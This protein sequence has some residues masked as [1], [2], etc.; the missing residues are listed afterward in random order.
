[1]YIC[2]Q[3]YS[4]L[5]QCILYTYAYNNSWYLSQTNT[6]I[7]VHVCAHTHTHTHTHT[8]AQSISLCTGIHFT[9]LVWY[10]IVIAFHYIKAYLICFNCFD[11]SELY[12]VHCTLYML[13]LY[14]SIYC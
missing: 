13:K 14:A 4:A 8:Y 10:L 2:I 1:M 9:Y 5:T 6:H 11:L 12:I 3:Y 7:H